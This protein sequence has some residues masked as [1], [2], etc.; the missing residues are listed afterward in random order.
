[1]GKSA[2]LAVLAPLV[3]VSFA[4]ADLVLSTSRSAFESANPVRTTEGLDSLDNYSIVGGDGTTVQTTGVTITGDGTQEFHIDTSAAFVSEPT[5]S[6]VVDVWTLGSSL[7]FEFDTPVTAFGI[8]FLD[9]DPTPGNTTD[10]HFVMNVYID[11]VFAITFQ[12]SS[13]HR[14]VGNGGVGPFFMGAWNTT[15]S[16]SK[17]VIESNFDIAAI[18]GGSNDFPANFDAIEFSAV[19]EP[20]A[21][22]FGGLVSAVAAGGSWLRRKLLACI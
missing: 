17:V 1:M 8:D 5:G 19:P 10:F 18:G 2:I 6:L 7:T 16:F 3:L 22:L 11:D 9:D 14:T 4:D 13:D 12:S 15:G 20:S 21:F